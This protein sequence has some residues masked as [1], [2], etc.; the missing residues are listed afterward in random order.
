[1]TAYTISLNSAVAPD[2]AKAILQLRHEMKSVFGWQ[3]GY[4]KLTS[5]PEALKKS[6]DAE[7]HADR[8][9]SNYCV[10]MNENAGPF[11]KRTLEWMENYDKITS[12]SAKTNRNL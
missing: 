9:V 11:A 7:V 6:A 1:M 3:L 10:A 8:F 5:T 12:F 4:G 2:D